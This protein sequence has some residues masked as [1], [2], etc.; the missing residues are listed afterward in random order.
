MA[1]DAK[2]FQFLVVPE[3]ANY[4][5]IGLEKRPLCHAEMRFQHYIALFLLAGFA[6]VEGLH[7]WVNF[8]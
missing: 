7:V 6:F 4:M 5:A 1:R 8:V 3:R 2:L